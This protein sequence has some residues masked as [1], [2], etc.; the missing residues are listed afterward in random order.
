MTPRLISVV[1]TLI[2]ALCAVPAAPA[3]ADRPDTDAPPGAPSDWLPPEEWVMERWLPFDEP[4]LWEVLRMKRHE[5]YGYLQ[6]GDRTLR[7]LAVER[8][9]PVDGLVDHLLAPRASQ[10]TPAQLRVL[11]ARSRRL[12]SQGH[13][14]EHVIGHNFHNWSLDAANR[15]LFGLERR[16]SDPLWHAGL[17]HAEIARRSG[18]RAGTLRRRTL[19]VL[20][21]AGRRG[22]AGGDLSREQHRELQAM[23]LEAI[24]LWLRTAIDGPRRPGTARAAAVGGSAICR[25]TPPTAS[26]R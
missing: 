3:V 4:R 5:V 20:A 11:Q 18:I 22:V 6:R 14:A 7:D 17:T 10:V 15:T 25:L 23:H 1:L 9:V 21:R 16:R 24:D 8:G 19:E 26:R 2:A 12:L 13:L